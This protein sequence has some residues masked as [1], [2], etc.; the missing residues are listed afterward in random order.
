MHVA[1]VGLSRGSLPAGSDESAHDAPSPQAALQA[2]AKDWATREQ[3][4]LSEYYVKTEGILLKEFGNF[5]GKMCDR[6]DQQIQK[7]SK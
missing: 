5:L 3:D 7:D 4:N 6:I 1:L 2:G